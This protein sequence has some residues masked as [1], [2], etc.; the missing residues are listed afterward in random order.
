MANPKLHRYSCTCP[1]Y[2]LLQRDRYSVCVAVGG[3]RG[4]DPDATSKDIHT[5]LTKFCSRAEGASPSI[6]TRLESHT[7]WLARCA[8]LEQAAIELQTKACQRRVQ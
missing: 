7:L 4:K 3:I 8:W 5:K 1:L 6:S 2:V